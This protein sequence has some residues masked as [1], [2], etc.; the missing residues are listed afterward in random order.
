M[1]TISAY[2]LQI[3]ILVFI[4]IVLA[5]S[6]N[7]VT[8]FTGQLSLG[9][10]AFM[11]IGAYTSA[12]LT[13]KAG[14]PFIAALLIGGIVAAIFGII[15]GIPTLRLKGDYLAI[16]TLGFGE[17]IRIV[18]LN[19]K[20]TGGTV[21]LRGIKQETTLLVV[22]IV[23]VLTIFTIRRIINSR[24]GRSF[25]S[26]REDE[27]AAEAMGIETTKYKVL[28]FALAAFYAGIA[29][30]LFAHFYRYINPNSFG[31]MRS[32]EIVSMVVLGG[33]GKISGSI[34]GATV[35]TAAPEILR[36]IAAYRQLIYGALLVIMMI[37]RPEG[38]LGDA[39]LKIP[40][41]RRLEKLLDR[42]S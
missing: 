30:G 35:L 9:H 14:L 36:P 18:A 12:I 7:L 1:I 13:L 40:F 41:Q 20:I 24:I 6:L 31:F 17:I 37:V 8:G 26:I 34:I 27:I 23:L 28:A 38:I 22:L 11:G 10:A 33:M 25:I 4:N 42:K 15:I 32:I 21:G 29:G 5:V 16:A 39:D 3:L 2:Y 19:L